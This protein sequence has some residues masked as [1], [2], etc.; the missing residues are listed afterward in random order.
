MRKDSQEL[1]R[2]KVNRI[3]SIT[4]PTTGLPFPNNIIP[5]SRFNPVSVAL[6]AYAV[7]RRPRAAAVPVAAPPAAESSPAQSR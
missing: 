7:L 2:V 3:S 6:L 1:A 5:Q 4:D